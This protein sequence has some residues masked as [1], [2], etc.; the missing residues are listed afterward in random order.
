MPSNPA[1]SQ[2]KIVQFQAFKDGTEL[3]WLNDAGELW[4]RYLDVNHPDGASWVMELFNTDDG[5]WI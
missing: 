5:Y 4:H 1:K 2:A 3:Y